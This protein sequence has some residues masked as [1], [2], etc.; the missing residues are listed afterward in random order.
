VS[1]ATA[2]LPKRRRIRRRPSPDVP[3]LA[4]GIELVGEY[5]DSGFKEPQFIARRADG[6]VIQLS[7]L[8]NI[9]A[10]QVDGKRDFAQIAERTGERFGRKVSSG[11]VQFL[12]EKQLRPLG[13]LAAADGS[14][15][16]LPKADPLL[17]LKFR[18][19]L[20]PPGS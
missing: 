5:E 20:I 18:T 1:A 15:P 8:L 13:V 19:A 11:N 14:S 16:S 9:V 7:E 6:Q 2:A 10:E 17:A 12:V 4:E 3:R